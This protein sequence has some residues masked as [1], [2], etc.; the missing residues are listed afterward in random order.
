LLTRYGI[1]VIGKNQEVLCSE[2][3]KV[4]KWKIKKG[5]IK[6][7]FVG[8]TKEFGSGENQEVLRG[9]NQEVLRGENQEVNNGF[10][11][12]RTYK[13]SVRPFCWAT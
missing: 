4:F 12:S 13:V 6:K 5:K 11:K 2:N 8:K 10:E 1:K 7:L 3:P 9:E